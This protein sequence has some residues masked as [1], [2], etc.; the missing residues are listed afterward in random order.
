V[1]QTPWP[2]IPYIYIYK[3]TTIPGVERSWLVVFF[4]GFEAIVVYHSF[5]VVALEVPVVWGTHQQHG[6]IS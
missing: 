2:Y 4:F 5:F 3:T 1:L 6:E